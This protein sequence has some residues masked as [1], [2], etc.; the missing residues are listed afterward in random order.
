[1]NVQEERHTIFE[2]STACMAPSSGSLPSRRRAARAQRAR[3]RVRS[4]RSSQC[5]RSLRA[6]PGRARLRPYE[7]HCARRR[8]L[9]V[10]VYIRS[11]PSDQG[12]ENEDRAQGS[13]AGTSY[14][15][16]DLNMI[17]TADLSKLVTRSHTK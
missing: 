9:Q 14:N 12:H 17:F 16:S 8:E 2:R 11:C 13:Q 10:A 5:Q 4:V 1:M 7:P 3:D 15:L 6:R